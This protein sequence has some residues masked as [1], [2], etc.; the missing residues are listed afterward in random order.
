MTVRQV[1]VKRML[2][3]AASAL[4]GA[5]VLVGFGVATPASAHVTAS[6]DDATP[7]AYTLLTFNAPTESADAG[8]NRLE[9]DFPKGTPITSVRSVPVPGWS[10]E[11]IREPLP[12]PVDNGHG[13]QISEAVARVVWT[14]D[15]NEEAVGPGETGLFVL[16]VGPLPDAASIAFPTVQGYTDGSEASWTQLSEAGDDTERPA[17]TIELGA[18]AGAGAAGA[19]AGEGAAAEASAPGEPGE[20][21]QLTGT[22]ASGAAADPAA[23]LGSPAANGVALALGGAGFVLGLL[24]LLSVRAN[25]RRLAG[26]SAPGVTAVGLT[27]EAAGTAGVAG[28]AGVAR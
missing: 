16:S 17:P 21:A 11:V 23:F 7:G 15:N 25:G 13:G 19:G 2:G 14:S 24:A 12:E 26:P 8:T 9:I 18:G 1:T 10:A 5:A 27:A 3:V 28:G 20:P 4:A 6:V 22:L